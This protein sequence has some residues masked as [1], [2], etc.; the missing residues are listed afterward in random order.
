MME[1]NKRDSKRNKIGIWE[2][3]YNNG[4]L[5]FK[6]NYINGIL[7]GEYIQ[8]YNNGQIN[9]KT[10]YING[11]D[12]GYYEKY[13]NN[14]KIVFKGLYKNDLKIDYWE[15]FKLDKFDNHKYFSLFFI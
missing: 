9:Y 8:Y 11:K 3:Y 1:I 13:Y 14:G 6:C 4:K 10:Y 12:D 15:E 5:Y 7:N 2:K